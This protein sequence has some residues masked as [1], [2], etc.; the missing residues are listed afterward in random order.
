[1]TKLPFSLT[2]VAVFYLC[3][4]RPYQKFKGGTYGLYNGKELHSRWLLYSCTGGWTSGRANSYSP[5]WDEVSGPDLAGAGHP[6]RP[7]WVR[8]GEVLTQLMKKCELEQVIL[9][10]PSMG[11]RIALEFAIA[12]PDSIKALVVVGPVGVEENRAGLSRITAPVLVIWG[13]EDQ[14]SP[15]AHSETLLDELADARREIYPQAP[16]PCY[17]EQPDRWHASLK[18]FLTDSIK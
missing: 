7:S 15:I 12:H 10:G 9:V 1:L 16:H 14:V 8:D 5:P 18:K 4:D 6:R 2:S 13:E 17:L 11:G 3:I